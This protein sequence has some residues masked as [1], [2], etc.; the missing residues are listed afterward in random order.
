MA[1]EFQDQI[2][3]YDNRRDYIVPGNKEETIDFSV[4]HL[5]TTGNQAI[6]DH[7]YFTLALSGGSTPKAIFQKLSQEKYKDQVDW[8]KVLLFWSDER[9]VGPEDD[10]SNY[11]MAFTNGMEKLPLNKENIFR[12][13][14]DLDPEFHAKDYEKILDQKLHM[15]RFDMVMLGMGDDGH[16]ASLFPKTHALHAPEKK[17][18]SNFIPKLDAWRMT[19]TFPCINDSEVIAIY[20]LGKNKSETVKKV[21]TAPHEPDKYPV[22]NIGTPGHKALWIMDKDAA[23]MLNNKSS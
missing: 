19:L 9:A 21:F 5:I 3:A 20:V 10:Q 6:E 1:V 8:S 18:A 11:K 14:A 2:K 4:H 12:M 16:T 13:K 15:G 17:V 7:G 22:Q 23:C